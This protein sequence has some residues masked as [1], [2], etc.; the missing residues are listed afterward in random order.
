M[1][2]LSYF[3]DTAEEA[4]LEI[5][6][7]LMHSF[8]MSFSKSA[9]DAGMKAPSA[10]AAWKFMTDD[11]ALARTVEKQFK[12]LGVKDD[13]SKVKFANLT[14][15]AHEKFIG[16]YKTLMSIAFSNTLVPDLR[17]WSESLMSSSDSELDE[18]QKITDYV[19]ELMNN[20][21]YPIN[22][23]SNML[24]GD[25]HS[26]LFHECFTCIRNMVHTI[27]LDNV[28]K[29]PDNRDAR[30]AVDAALRLKIG[31]K[32]TPAQALSR[33]YL[34]K[35]ALNEHAS[36][37]ALENVTQTRNPVTA[38]RRVRI[39]VICKILVEGLVKWKQKL[40]GSLS[41]LD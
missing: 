16:L 35:A 11:H 14:S 40:A 22:Q 18:F 12:A 3:P 4:A 39:G 32:C 21:A 9:E 33:H 19:H 17:L 30:Q 1:S 15:F 38:A 6:I 41:A 25:G 7:S 36:L 10:F 37:Q 34:M 8:I 2:G 29:K 20:K 13:C 28:R 5:C 23:E 27:S 31:L 26:D 24:A